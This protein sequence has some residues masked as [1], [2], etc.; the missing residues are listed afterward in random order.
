MLTVELARKRLDYDRESGVFV[1]RDGPRKGMVAGRMI[2]PYWALSIGKRNY[3]A[4]RVAWLM[5]YGEW[6]KGEI[7][8]RNQIKTD[9]RIDNLRDTTKSRNMHNVA[10][11]RRDSASG[12][13]GVG[14][15]I[16]SQRWRAQL[17]VN[18][19]RVHLGNF[20]TKEEAFDAYMAAKVAQSLPIG[21]AP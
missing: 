18:G 11:A 5:H 9:N 15:H 2:G 6:P 7:D 17:C 12:L 20:L 3:S 13:R 21:G 10:S 19:K 16:S 4:H 8:H 1:W 14:W